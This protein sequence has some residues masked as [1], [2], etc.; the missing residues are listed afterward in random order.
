MRP[1]QVTGDYDGG[2]RASAESGPGGSEDGKGEHPAP[3]LLPFDLHALI[4]EATGPLTAAAA[5]KELAIEILT[6][7]DLPREVV[8]DA[9]G[10][11]E[12]LSALLENAVRFTE[13]GEVVASVVAR[14]R[15]SGRAV[16]HFEI[17]DTG[18]G[19]PA[20]ALD[21]AGGGGLGRSLRAVDRMDGRIE[22]ASAAGVGSTMAFDVPVDVAA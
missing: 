3:R 2:H 20:G 10:V 16:V 9:D 13:Q 14:A 12:V 22:C 11:R 7:S 17:S 15:R 1:P 21:G 19:V 8:G 6:S 4:E 18:P 5:D